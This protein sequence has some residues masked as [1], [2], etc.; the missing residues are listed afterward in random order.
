MLSPSTCACRKNAPKYDAVSLAVTFGKS[1]V[2]IS[3]RM[4]AKIP[5]MRSCIFLTID[6]SNWRLSHLN[7]RCMLAAHWIKRYLPGAGKIIN[8]IQFYCIHCGQHLATETDMAR[9]V[10]ESPG[11]I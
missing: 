1:H 5:M 6:I 7:R 11:S 8:E 4:V 9:Q 3:N 2:F 10:L